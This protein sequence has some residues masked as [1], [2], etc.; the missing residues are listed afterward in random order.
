MISMNFLSNRYSKMCNKKDKTTYDLRADVIV[1][2]SSNEGNA[3]S[4][5]NTYF[6]GNNG[7]LN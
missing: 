6:S 4:N 2:N 3:L 1:K 5:K 7:A